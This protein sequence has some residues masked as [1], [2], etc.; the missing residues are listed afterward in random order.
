MTTITDTEVRVRGME[1][2]IAALGEV[3]AEKFITLIMREPFDYTEW[4]RTL[5]NNKTVEEISKM[6]MERRRK[7]NS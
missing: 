5:W 2:L 7:T 3:H 4:Q 6:A 1:A